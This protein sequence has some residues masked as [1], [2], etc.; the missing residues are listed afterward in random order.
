MKEN[1]TYEDTRKTYKFSH[2]IYLNLG[3]RRLTEEKVDLYP[4]VG[5]SEMR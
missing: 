2:S 3:Q 4:A 5:D 1:V